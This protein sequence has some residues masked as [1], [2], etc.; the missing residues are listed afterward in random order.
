MGFG[1]APAR[2]G[3]PQQGDD[4][5]R[6]DQR[7]VLEGRRRG[8]PGAAAPA[9]PPRPGQR[10]AR[11][12]RAWP[13][14]G[15][16]ACPRRR[17]ASRPPS[18]RRRPT[19]PSVRPWPW[20]HLYGECKWPLNGIT[21]PPCPPGSPLA[22]PSCK[23]AAALPLAASARALAFGDNAR[24]IPAVAQHGGKLGCPP[25]RPAPARVGAAA[26][27][28]G[29]G[30]ARRAALPARAARKLFEYPFLYLGGDGETCPPLARRTR[31]RTCGATSPSAASCSRTPTTAPTAAASTPA[32]AGRSPGCCRRARSATLPAHARRLQD[33]SSCWTRRP[34]GCSTS[35]SSQAAQRGQA[36]GGHLLAERPGRRLEPRRRRR[37][38]SSRS[39]PG[40]EPQRELAFR[41]GINLCMYA[42][43]LD[44]KDDA[45]HLP[46]ILKSGGDAT[47]S[48]LL[49]TTPGSWSAS[50]RC[51]VGAGAA[52][53]GV[54]RPG[55]VLA[56]L[57]LRREPSRARQCCSG[58]LRVAAG[59]G[60]ALLPARARHPQPPGGADEEPG[61]GAGGPLRLHGLPGRARRARPAPRRWA[62]T[63]SASQPDARRAPGPLHGGALR[64]R[65]GARPRHPGAAATRSRRARARTDLLAA[66]RALQGGGARQRVARSSP[67]C[68]S[69][70]DGADN[71]ELAQGVARH[72]RGARSRS[73][74]CRSP[75][76]WWARRRSRTSR[77]SR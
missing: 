13:R 18:S 51:R 46:L 66:L 16:P 62:S 67:A 61:G 6:G 54:A 30:G 5:P 36:R 3:D 72:A 64:L 57:G 12:A 21:V 9:P 15:R 53:R 73:W 39:S 75:R 31:W 10:A 55:V 49:R 24:F 33:A 28:L 68:C 60:G 25:V 22:E 8:E 2:E 23:A 47:S 38:T 56:A 35:R 1:S 19:S 17:T 50:R 58:R 14:R 26:A 37:T 4:E 11:R 52:R 44:Y 69:S 45:V 42:L 71:A 65:P 74:A 59:R 7:Q 34:G 20:R 29:G 32:S 43:C 40:G 48:E 76:S 63:S 70:R 27:H 41:L 77:W